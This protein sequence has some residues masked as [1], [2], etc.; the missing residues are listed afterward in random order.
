MSRSRF[1]TFGR[2]AMALA[3]V[4]GGTVF[5]A[6]PAMAAPPTI[7]TPNA[8]FGFPNVA[9]P[10][11]GTD[12]YSGDNRA[13][14]TNAQS[15]DA[16]CVNLDTPATRDASGCVVVYLSLNNAGAGT[17]S[18][19]TAGLWISSGTVGSAGFQFNATAANAVTALS[20]LV[21]TPGNNQTNV[22]SSPAALKVDVRDGVTLDYSGSP[23]GGA[24]PTTRYVAIRI[25]DL[26]SAP[27]NTVPGA[28]TVAASST[29]DY[30]GNVFT[31]ADSD[32]NV[33][34]NDGMLLIM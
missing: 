33:E 20:T 27:V 30:T 12:P 24:A 15:N 16:K 18:L 32:V 14:T 9:L 4:I 17:I 34:S 2:S 29:T 31:V 8:V 7:T 21:Y 6:S 1:S 25:A 5:F 3:L 19:N 28:K 26:N 11:T 13:I 10:F 22:P 23:N